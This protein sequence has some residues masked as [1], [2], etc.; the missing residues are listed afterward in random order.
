[1]KLRSLLLA[2]LA[3]A[4]AGISYGQTYDCRVLFS[5]S[6]TGTTTAPFDNRSNGCDTWTLVYQANNL[7]GLS[8]TLQST[9]GATGPG[10]WVT[11]VGTVV[12]GIN[13]NTSTTGAQTIVSGFNSF[14]R[15]SA[16]F[17]DS[18]G[19]LING[20]L[21]GYHSGYNPSNV[22]TCPGTAANPCVVDGPNAAGVPPTKAPVLVA[23][24]D[25]TN[26]R[27]IKTDTN[28]QPIILD[29]Q[30]ANSTATW[31][32]STTISTA[33]TVNTTGFANITFG[34]NPT[35][36]ISGGVISFEGSTDGV[37]F[38]PVSAVGIGFANNGSTSITLPAS[39]NIWQMYIGGLTQFRL[40]LSTVITG[41]GSEA[42]TLTTTAAPAE[43]QQIV[44]QASGLN[45]HVNADVLPGATTAQAD[46]QTNSP[47]QPVAS[48][49]GTATKTPVFP[50][51]FNG[52]TWDRDFVCPLSAP[53]T[54]SAASGSLQVV[55]ASG[56]TIIR[57]CHVSIATSVATN[58]TVQYGTG[59]N[60]G[61]GTVSL[62]GAYNNVQSIALDFGSGGA[63]RAPASQ[64][65]CINSSVA[66]TA[67]GVVSYAQF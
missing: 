42:L 32:S 47:M 31:D 37:N 34:I 63:L 20:V 58:I 15:M 38:V 36:V 24:Q 27:T 26:V 13:P 46:G 18:G 1:M 29:A 16:T 59:S 52:A 25:G 8:L 33:L 51:K 9:N 12:S 62:T 54:F 2:A 6:T 17:T 45:L 56:S 67:G 61:T 57:V 19:A 4:F 65:L 43:F 21:Y 41:A 60:C 64:A 14:I 23:G 22:G 66:V 48:V 5:I 49:A 39:G 7:T 28:G 44:A 10:A 35:G 40:R 55:A 11:F 50:Y 53:I 3:L 30:P